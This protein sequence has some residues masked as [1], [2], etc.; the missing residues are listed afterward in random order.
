MVFA[1]VA[2]RVS[3]KNPINLS[4]V[5]HFNKLVTFILKTCERQQN[6]TIVTS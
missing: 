2:T 5:D 1:I 4:I 6:P 3:S